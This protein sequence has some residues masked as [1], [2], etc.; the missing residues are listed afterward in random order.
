[1]R[2]NWAEQLLVDTSRQSLNEVHFAMR[3]RVGLRKAGLLSPGRQLSPEAELVLVNTEIARVK[4]GKG[5]PV[6][7]D[8][9]LA[10]L[11]CGEEVRLL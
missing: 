10:A 1:M 7:R 5:H 3:A 11:M 2:Q 8:D 6:D 9:I 4:A